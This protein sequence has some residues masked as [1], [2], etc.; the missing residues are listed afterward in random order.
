MAD[1]PHAAKSQDFIERFTAI[2]AQWPDNIAILTDGAQAVTYGELS[3][4]AA[5]IAT[6]L[7]RQNVKPGELV[8]LHIE[9]SSD[10]IAAQLGC[11]M[12]GAA[13]MPLDPALPEERRNFILKDSGVTNVFSRARYN[14]QLDSSAVKITN[15][16]D[17]PD[18]GLADFNL[19]AR[20]KNDPEQLAYVIYTSGS[21]GKPK[22]VMVPHRG[23]CNFLDEQIEAF[24]LDEKSRSL[25]YLSTS[26][27]ASISDIWTA[28]L[29]G[30]SL[31]IESLSAVET[32]SQLNRIVRDRGITYMDI[33]PSLLRLLTPQDAPPCLK[34]IAIGGEPCP[35]DIVRD[36]A[37]SL[38]V[39]NV[40]G[41]TEATVCTSYVVCD[42][43]TWE[44][45]HIGKPMANVE[46]RVV[47]KDMQAVAPGEEGELLI[48]GIQL[49]LGYLNRPDLTEKKFIELD[50]RKFYRT[51]DL[52]RSDVSGSPVFL[53]RLD[54]Q[55]KLRGQL[56]ELEEVE[57]AILKNPAVAQVA[58]VKR[59]LNLSDAGKGCDTLVAFVTYKDDSD[60]AERDLKKTLQSALPQW[61][62][63]RHFIALDKM[64][65]TATGK[66]DQQ[67]LAQS[68]ITAQTPEKHSAA[69]LSQEEQ[70]LTEIWQRVLKIQGIGPKEDFFDLGG[71][72]LGV[73]QVS[74]EAELHG[75]PL[76]PSK[77]IE[78]RTISQLADWIREQKN[79]NSYVQD[80][81]GGRPVETLRQDVALDAEWQALIAQAR[82][83]PR[84]AGGRPGKVLFTGATGFL[85]PRLM[86][87]MMQKSPDTVFY[88]VV[89]AADTK[90]ALDRLTAAFQRQGIRMTPEI[91][92][93]IVPVCGDFS[94]PR[95]GLS[96]KQWNDYAL[97]IDSIVHCGATVNMVLPYE[98]LR[99]ANVGGTQEVTKFALTARRKPLHY[100]STL[101]VFVSTDQN[102]GQA[103]ESDRLE[104]TTTV[105]GGYGQTK[106]AAEH[107]L[108]QIPPDVLEASIYRLGLITG[109]TR[110]GEGSAKDFINMFMHGVV[111]LGCVPQGDAGKMEVDV[112]PIDYCSAAMAHIVLL[113]HARKGHEV[114][115]IANT[116]GFSLEMI[117]ETLRERGHAIPVVSVEEWQRRM[118]ARKHDGFTVE[119]SAAYLGLSR[120]LPDALAFERNR[121]FDL[122]QATGIRFDQKNTHKALAGTGLSCPVADKKLLHIYLNNV[123]KTTDVQPTASERNANDKSQRP[124]SR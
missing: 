45:P 88:A 53:G 112:T 18:A 116:K 51:G 35:P 17:I 30:S 110:T 14:A 10:Y 70:L 56:I 33:P 58:V 49:A 106:W 120:L 15:I 38:R 66:I 114:Y 91:R 1:T 98:S 99:D 111:A 104:N 29:S 79:N 8:A 72:S 89:R 55:I 122:F 24:M 81:A 105:F 67:A 101:S 42:P 100:A 85:G 16:E 40:Y 21:T 26:F 65:L 19:A 118:E 61:M 73:L 12:A 57:A 13:F 23:L 102:T 68:A 83:L 109:D 52:V 34:T 94:Q 86:H 60:P 63:P 5:A 59:P 92:R 2:A 43:Q 82:Q 80:V 115:H 3:A 93:H 39:V 48:G 103:L 108:H 28:L 36:W 54:R 76:S 75:I 90:T 119:E 78:L 22:G 7:R 4:K 31:C 87:D 50:G 44:K 121:A 107:F 32:A 69:D 6:A 74:L 41:P 77:L 71:D 113:P 46:Y 62:I 96:E 47:D 20:Q 64:P 124:G 97:K 27:D 95:F 11:W 84:P 25:F 37:Q 117:L 9:K 123:M